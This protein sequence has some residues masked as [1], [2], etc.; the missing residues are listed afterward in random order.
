MYSE[1]IGNRAVIRHYV[2]TFK[3]RGPK[4]IVHRILYLFTIKERLA[5]WLTVQAG[6]FTARVRILVALFFLP[7]GWRLRRTDNRFNNRADYPVLY[8]T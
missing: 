2:S 4:S 7:G 8:S 1:N 3:L 5:E 6:M